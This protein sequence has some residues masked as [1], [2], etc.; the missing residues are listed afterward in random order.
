MTASILVVEHDDD[1]R[2]SL[3][4]AI[5]DEWIT[6]DSVDNGRAALLRLGMQDY[7]GVLLGSP[8]PVDFG[9]ENA[10]MLEL[11]D[12]LAPNLAPRLIV[13]T[14]A[15]AADIIQRAVQ[16]QVCAVF[17]AP[18]DPAE[19]RQVVHACLRGET[20]PRRLYGTVPEVERALED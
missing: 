6:I 17:V 18:F 5:Q 4:S 7:D 13:V 3:A 9:S 19:L 20:L 16:M 14:A 12:R 11:F 15:E 10:T 8:V 2:A 1:H